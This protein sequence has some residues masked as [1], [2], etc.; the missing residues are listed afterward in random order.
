MR[1]GAAAVAVGAVEHRQFAAEA[2]QD[3]LGGEFFLAFLVGPFAGF[4]L[5]LDID[6]GAFFQIAFGDADQMLVKNRDAVPFGFFLFFAAGLVFPAFGGRD[7]KAGDAVAVLKSADF[8]VLAQ[9]ADENDLV[10]AASHDDLYPF[11]PFLRRFILRP[12]TRE[13]GV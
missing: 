1:P 3:D 6:L 9:I 5:A 12:V 13:Y 11:L 2:R 7:R 4:Q 8:G 10:D